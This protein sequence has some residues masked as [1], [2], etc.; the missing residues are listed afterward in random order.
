MRDTSEEI[1]GLFG[2]VQLLKLALKH[3]V[4][5]TIMGG[6]IVTQR[7]DDYHD[8]HVVTVKIVRLSRYIPWFQKPRR[9]S[10]VITTVIT[11]WFCKLCRTLILEFCLLSTAAATASSVRAEN[12]RIF[13]VCCLKLIQVLGWL[14][15]S[16]GVS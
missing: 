6:V 3:K 2:S 14:Y 10:Y 12:W 16:L 9:L 1:L 4:H 15:F 7:F 5:Q 11:V 8:N 13:R